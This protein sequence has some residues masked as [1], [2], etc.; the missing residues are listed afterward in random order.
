[1]TDKEDEEDMPSEQQEEMLTQQPF[2]TH[3]LSAWV[4]RLKKAIRQ[5]PHT[6]QE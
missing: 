6:Q 3:C 4:K 1:M 5:L 2:A